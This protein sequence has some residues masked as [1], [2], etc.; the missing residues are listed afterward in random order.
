MLCV[1]CEMG[2]VLTLKHTVP[3]DSLNRPWNPQ[4][5]HPLPYNISVRNGVYIRAYYGAVR[6]RN[7]LADPGSGTRCLS[8]PRRCRPYRT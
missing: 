1:I 8:I 4:M 5:S 6:V 2:L 7:S 3:P